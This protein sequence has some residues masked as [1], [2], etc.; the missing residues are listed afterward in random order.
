MG[1]PAPR[2]PVDVLVG[3]ARTLDAAGLPVGADR[4]LLLIRA[5]A[6]LEPTSREDLGIAARSTLCGGP[7]DLDVVDQALAATFDGADA[8]T[9]TAS[10][11]PVLGLSMRSEPGP[12]DDDDSAAEPEEART[13]PSVSTAELLRR[14][15]I[16]DLS[17]PELEELGRLLAAFRLTADLRRTRRH[18]PSHQGDID[19]GATVRELL[20]S[21]GE[22]VRLLHRRHR[23]RPRRVVLLVDVSGSMGPYTDAWLRFA[24]AASRR[25]PVAPAGPRTEVFTLG[26]RLTRVSAE[27]ATA[28]P[29]TAMAAVTAAVRDWDGGTRLGPLVEEFL[30]RWGRRGM[31]RGAVV[32]IISDGWER[33]DASLLG[34][35]MRHLSRLAHRVVWANPCK[36]RPGYQPLVGGMAAALPYVDV[37]VEGH[38]L[39]ALEHL[40][41]VVGG[42]AVPR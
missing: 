16:A 5:L 21:A 6:L 25:D 15:D 33:G 37:F 23:R 17:E 27:L 39:G 36:A 4:L 28:D 29:D 19:P 18:E 10:Q 2:D 8:S 7:A 30:D 41:R 22:P 12:V 1:E 26:T 13:E 31:V 14:R 42:H 38:S 24:H 11:P 35:Q 3:L 20:R 32:V 34:E 9:E 40:A